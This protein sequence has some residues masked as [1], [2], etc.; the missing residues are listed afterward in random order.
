M[1]EH[2]LRLDFFRRTNN[3]DSIAFA[4]YSGK[5][6]TFAQSLEYFAHCIK[7]IAYPGAT[8]GLVCTDTLES[9]ILSFF[10]TLSSFPVYFLPSDWL[11]STIYSESSLQI[12]YL[13][14]TYL[15]QTT[16]D[17]Y[18]SAART[19]INA[20]TIA[21]FQRLDDSDCPETLIKDVFFSVNSALKYYLSSGSTGKPKIIP[22][23]Y[24]NINACYG[25]VV[26]AIY[27]QI[28][29]Y[30]IVSLHNT[31]FVITL[32]FLFSF[33]YNPQSVCYARSS[34]ANSSSILQLVGCIKLLNSPLLVTVPSILRALVSLSA[35][36][37]SASEFAII[38]CGEPLS[39]ELA[40]KIESLDPQSF[41]NLYGSTEVSPWIL[42]LDVLAYLKVY[43]HNAD[44][45]IVPAGVPLPSV[46]TLL[47]GTQSELVVSCPSMFS[48]YLQ[49]PPLSDIFVTING[50][51]YFRTGDAFSYFGNYLCCNG[52]INS[53]VKLAG[54]FVNPIILE[55]KI[56]DASV[57]FDYVVVPDVEKSS[58]VLIVFDP[59]SY[60]VDNDINRVVDKLRAV[61]NKTIPVR[62]MVIFEYP[63]Y[64]RSGKLD[65]YH[66]LDMIRES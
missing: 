62:S 54:I 19:I 37:K 43:N 7:D 22:L 25:S 39:N 48:G 55:T 58:L 23:S 4:D 44:I 50:A 32:P 28:E 33:S 36:S 8:I 13:V 66:Y 40:L 26:E 1:Q 61:V 14:F 57:G 45:P 41:Y 34:L 18:Q 20:P 24:S 51:L 42:Y 47:I 64:L 31:S 21:S 27:P 30:E 56:R 6:Y 35:F 9:H 59:L 10:F 52:R 3:K 60:I 15:S 17:K 16:P 63:V 29:F 11:T 38:S 46:S 53:A 5:S 12:E 65:R 2:D 49:G